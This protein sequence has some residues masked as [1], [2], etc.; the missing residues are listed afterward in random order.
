MCNL[1]VIVVLEFI[2][3]GLYLLF[4]I[5]LLKIPKLNFLPTHEAEIRPFVIFMFEILTNHLLTTSLILNNWA[6]NL[7]IDVIKT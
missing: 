4:A 7:L 3:R 6:Q 1:N 5:L 2:S